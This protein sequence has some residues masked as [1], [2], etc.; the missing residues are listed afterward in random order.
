MSAGARAVAAVAIGALLGSWVATFAN[1]YQMR[2]QVLANGAT[3]ATGLTGSG[4]VLLGT[5]GQPAVGTS[6]GTNL[7]LCSGFWCFGGIRVVSVDDR[8]P[9]IDLPAELAFGKPYPSP[10][11]GAVRFA[12]ALPKAARVELRVMD[13]QGRLVAAQG[14]RFEPGYRTLTWN[15]RDAGGRPVS[16]GVYFARLVVEGELVGQRRIVMRD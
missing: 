2:G 10:A 9:G 12:L 8:P 11:P 6:M 14:E 16:S 13:I 15:G 7:E 1:A 4:R 3:P 5:A